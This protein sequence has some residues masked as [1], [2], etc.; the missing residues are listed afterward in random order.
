MRPGSTGTRIV[1]SIAAMSEIMISAISMS[2]SYLLAL[3]YLG[4]LS[5]TGQTSG[6]LMVAGD[7]SLALICPSD[8]AAS[9]VERR[10]SHS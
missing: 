5:T 1:E 6:I 4:D 9:E 3:H 10:K 7:S 8:S 2:H